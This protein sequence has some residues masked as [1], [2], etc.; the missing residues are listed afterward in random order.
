MVVDLTPILYHLPGWVL[1][2]FRI[3]GIF[4]FAPVLGSST[5]PRQVKIG[6]AVTLAFCAYPALAGGTG[7]TAAAFGAINAMGLELWRLPTLA[8]TE[9]LVGLVIGY[10]ATLPLTAMQIGGQLIDQQMGLGIAGVYNPELEEQSGVIAEVLFIFALAVFV[11]AGGHRV[12]LATLIGSFE[13]IPPAAMMNPGELV[14]LVVGLLGVTFELAVR[15]AAPITAL[16]MLLTV[17]MGF[18]ARTVPQF[19]ILSVGFAIRILAAF[20]VLVPGIAVMGAVFETEV[21]WFMRTIAS[22]WLGGD[23]AL[24][25]VEGE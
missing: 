18:I 22:S 1:V 19:N 8:A 24:Y 25:F 16:L 9:L 10:L 21:V 12:M 23:L 14:E 6:L 2:L 13:H 17:G 3:S 7:Q 20:V 11:L 5:I 15:V 4:L